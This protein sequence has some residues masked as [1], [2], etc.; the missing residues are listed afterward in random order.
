MEQQLARCRCGVHAFS[1]RTKR[2]LPIFQGIHYLQQVRKGATQPIQLPDN[3][4]VTWTNK[5]QHL[6]QPH[7]IILRSRGTVFIQVSSIDPRRQQRV[8]LQV[9]VLSIRVR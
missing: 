3:E 8:T 1:K 7:P 4:Y 9:S 2:H 6:G 5:G